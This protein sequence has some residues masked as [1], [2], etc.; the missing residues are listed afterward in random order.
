MI[1]RLFP[2]YSSLHLMQ[3]VISKIQEVF[4]K[5][6]END[7]LI[8]TLCVPNPNIFTST[9]ANKNRRR[10]M[11]DCHVIITG[12]QDLFDV[13][14]CLKRPYLLYSRTILRMFL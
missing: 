5:Y 13:K 9:F 10:C 14:V 1:S 8:S 6:G 4:R 2:V 7:E 11:E 12:L 3:Y